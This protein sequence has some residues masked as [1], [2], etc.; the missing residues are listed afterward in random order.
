MDQHWVKRTHLVTHACH[1]LVVGLRYG[2]LMVA[3]NGDHSVGFVVCVKFLLNGSVV[4]SLFIKL[5]LEG[6]R[7]VEGTENL[8]GK[9]FHVPVQVTIQ[10]G[11]LSCVDDRISS[12]RRARENGKH[13]H[14][15]DQVE[16]PHPSC[17][18]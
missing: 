18:A 13:A 9:S 8:G 3:E 2:T 16:R 5:N 10:L 14:E 6:L 17:S 4:W 12:Y 11:G 1:R 15:H 7:S